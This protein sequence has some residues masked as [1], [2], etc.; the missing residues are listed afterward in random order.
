MIV[1]KYNSDIALKVVNVKIV[2]QIFEGD[3]FES[4]QF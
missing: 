1:P 2:V 3:L 4:L